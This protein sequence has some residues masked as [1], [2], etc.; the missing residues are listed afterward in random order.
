[1]RLVPMFAT[2]ALAVGIAA[3]GDD[4]SDP[5][6]TQV[7]HASHSAALP[8]GDDIDAHFEVT[9]LPSLG[10]PVS[11]ARAL[12]N[13]GRVAGFSDN[14]DGETRQA[15]AWRGGAL[16]ELGTL[17]GPSSSVVWHGQNEHGTVVGIAE[18]AEPDPE[19]EN[20]SCFFFLPGFPEH[21]G[22]S[23]RG[24]AWEGGTMRELPTL[25]GHNSFATG[26][27]NRGQ[28]VGWAENTVR[29]PTCL[30]ESQVFQFRAVIWGPR[31]GEIEELPPLPGDSVSAATAINQRGQ[32]VGISGDCDQAVGRESARHAV[33]WDRGQVVDLGSFGAAAWNTPMYISDRGDVVGFAGP[34][35]EEGG[36]LVA[37]IWTPERGMESID[38]VQGCGG[39][40]QA[41]AVNQD[42]IVVGLGG[43]CPDQRTR[44]FLWRKG[45]T[46][47]L[48]DLVDADLGLH[49]LS[50]TD[51]NSRGQIIGA[52]LDLE[53][54]RVVPFLATPRRG[55]GP[56]R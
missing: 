27:N 40:H 29:D 7:D 31:D 56:A 52:A 41:Q 30:P 25:G 15:V 12:S 24:F 19:G 28:I 51:V 1:M 42:R 2:V 20:F 22:H 14:P 37:F 43:G 18:T 35:P 53:T 54:E 6:A 8:G 38:P 4:P 44:A 45:V 3:C 26:V 5:P 36:G 39:S 34:S 13:S 11:Q 10:G 46:H 23:C 48:N 33:L 32:V 21:S 16:T 47:D 17:G 55:S 49:L 50:A 9:V